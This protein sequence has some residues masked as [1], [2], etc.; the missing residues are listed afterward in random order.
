MCTRIDFTASPQVPTVEIPGGPTSFVMRRPKQVGMVVLSAFDMYLEV[1]IGGS[2]E[3]L[4]DLLLT[5]M[6]ISPYIFGWKTVKAKPVC[7]V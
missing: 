1:N 6:L 2:A 7:G 5:A 3:F 4:Q